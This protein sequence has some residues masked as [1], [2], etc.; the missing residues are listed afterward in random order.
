MFKN[1]KIN[2]LTMRDVAREAGVS[3]STVSHYLN[4][5]APVSAS[6]CQKIIEAIQKLN[7][8]PNL[9][10][11]NLKRKK[12][13]TIG[14]FIPDMMNLYYAEL[15]KG[16]TD[17]AQQEG[18]AVILYAT[19]YRREME[20]EFVDLVLQQQV[21][22]VI[23]AYNF[24][25][26]RL[27]KRLE[28]NQAQAVMLDVY[29]SQ[30]IGPTIVIDGEKGIHEA[31]NYLYQLGH[32][33]YAFLSEPPYVLPL[34]IRNRAFMS[35]L[36]EKNI[37]VNKEWVLVEKRQINRVEIGFSL[38][39]DLLSRKELPTAVLTSSDLVAVGAIK[40]FLSS[41]IRVPDD[42]SVVGFDDI[43][44]A[45]YIHPSLTTIAQP[46]YQMG[47]MSVE[48]LLKIMTGQ[49]LPDSFMINV[50]EPKLVVRLSTGI[51]KKKSY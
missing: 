22:G 26:E 20:G 11:R 36:K 21:D 14:L 48:L 7:Y 28:E 6:T 39:K 38:G 16:V 2:N 18:Y 31:V 1:G 42:I 40:A 45:S 32:R 24:I 13:N 5:S 41:G 44:L 9:I 25:D 43:T 17:A 27:W 29:P 33:D 15:A 23:I 10:A 30:K 12:S 49:I 47:R 3:Q 34:I 37:P 35:V 4:K 46:K 51:P 19:G 50:F 8:Q